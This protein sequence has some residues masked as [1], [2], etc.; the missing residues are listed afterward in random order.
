MK[1]KLTAA[2]LAAVTLAA[3]MSASAA[4]PEEE[5]NALKQRIAQLEA[6]MQMV[7][8]KQ[9]S[10]AKAPNITI[11]GESRSRYQWADEGTAVDGT[12]A[13][14][15][16]QRLYLSA[17][18]NEH[19]SY[20]GRLEATLKNGDSATGTTRFNRN[21]FTIT[22]VGID[23]MILG[24][25][26]AAFGMSLNIDKGVDNDGIVLVQQ[27]GKVT[28]TGFVLNE[29]DKNIQFNGIYAGASL[30]KDVDM[31]VGYTEGD[32][33]TISGTPYARAKSLDIGVAYKF[34]TDYTA[35]GEFVDTSNS[36]LAGVQDGNAW[37]VQVVKGLTTKKVGTLTTNLLIVDKDK[38][39]TEGYIASYRR[40][41]PNGLWA[42][43]L[44]SP[45]NNN[46]S[47]LTTTDNI[48]GI[49]LG[50]QNV[51]AKNTVFTLEYQDLENVSGAGYENKIFQSHVQFFF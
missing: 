6:S 8:K 44:T 16:R 45:F 9:T 20:N 21:Y 10:A 49:Y 22:D 27:A 48:K 29:A 11:T 5:I 51:V 1:K 23:K 34:G 17:K 7:E 12:N 2:I 50:Y 18:I 41:E 36:D 40:V 25:M 37:A 4:T 47:T 38:P 3:T 43:G 30:S 42:R 13:F 26:P 28:F 35:V 32:R 14:D 15:L 46:N 39:H 33:C 24:R 19:V 31:A